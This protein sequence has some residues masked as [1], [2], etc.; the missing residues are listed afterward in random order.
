MNS[1]GAS[2]HKPLFPRGPGLGLKTLALLLVCGGLM[3]AELDGERIASPREWLATALRPVVWMAEIP[4]RIG[5]FIEHLDSR[6]SLLHENITLKTDYTPND[7]VNAFARVGYFSE[8]RW[9]GKVG[10]VNDTRWT[11]VNGGVRLRMPEERTSE[12]FRFAATS[13]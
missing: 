12:R 11:T 7:R 5:L 8:D 2:H 1:L 9:N 6:Q 3:A 10:E 13:R 4:T